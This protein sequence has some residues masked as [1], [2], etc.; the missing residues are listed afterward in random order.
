M[1]CKLS[2]FMSDTSPM[3][4]VNL[5]VC[6]TGII[7]FVLV[8]AQLLKGYHFILRISGMGRVLFSLFLIAGY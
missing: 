2:C 6:K 5:S 1:D 8:G 3:I 4:R 7:K